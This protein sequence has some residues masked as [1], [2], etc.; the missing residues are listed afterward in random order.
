[1]AP[2]AVDIHSCAES[3]RPATPGRDGHDLGPPEHA[4]RRLGKV[5]ACRR[6]DDE[7][8][9]DQQHAHGPDAKHDDQ[10]QQTGKG[11][12]PQADIDA[13]DTR[14]DRIEGDIEQTVVTDDLK[15]Q[16]GDEQ[17]GQTNDLAPGSRSARHRK[18]IAAWCGPCP[19][20][21]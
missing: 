20:G 2:L 17:N 14:H 13:V 16:Q 4:A 18:G 15:D 3:S 19:A 21:G 6:R 8:G 12:L 10:G 5:A 9:R 1:M 11:V 7:H